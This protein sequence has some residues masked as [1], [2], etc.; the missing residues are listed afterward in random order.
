MKHRAAVFL[1]AAA[2][3]GCVAAPL[4][5]RAAAPPAAI[6]AGRLSE[7]TRVLASDEFQGRAPGTPGGTTPATRP[8]P[9]A[10][11]WP[12]ASSWTGSGSGCGCDQLAGHDHRWLRADVARR[13]GMPKSSVSRLM[14]AMGN[15]G[16]GVLPLVKLDQ[17][18]WLFNLRGSDI[19]YNPVFIAYADIPAARTAMQEAEALFVSAVTIWEVSVKRAL[20]KL[21]GEIER[22]LDEDGAEAIVLGCAGMADLAYEPFAQGE[23]ARE[24]I[25]SMLTMQYAPTDRLTFTAD[26][27][28]AQN[29]QESWNVS[30]LPFFVRQFDFVAFDGNPVVSLPDFISEPLVAGAGSVSVS[31]RPYGVAGTS[32]SGFAA[33]GTTS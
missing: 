7:I 9:S 18:A 10:A 22:A 17:I 4:A 23:S 24:R 20:G 32:A 3:G 26:A 28:F 19:P 33:A 16:A 30:D 12:C 21:R 1:L 15:A 5:E 29:D 27:M 2:L 8:Y 6:D 25:N 13:L 31:Q 11:S 14:K